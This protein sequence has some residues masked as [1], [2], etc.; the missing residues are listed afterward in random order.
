MFK[1]PMY[2]PPT[3]LMI[4]NLDQKERIKDLYVCIR[5]AHAKHDKIANLKCSPN[6][7]HLYLIPSIHSNAPLKAI[8]SAF[9]NST[10]MHP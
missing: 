3:D 4:K 10:L 9:T 1:V 5:V 6:N 8:A 2:M 7:K